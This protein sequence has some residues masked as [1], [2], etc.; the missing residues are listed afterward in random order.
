MLIL[1]ISSFTFRKRVDKIKDSCHTNTYTH[2]ICLI[3]NSDCRATC[4][5]TVTHSLSSKRFGNRTS[6]CCCYA[7]YCRYRF[8]TQY[9]IQ[10]ERKLPHSYITTCSFGSNSLYRAYWSYCVEVARSVYVLA[11]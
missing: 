6:C 8:E 5:H 2:H 3:G 10:T 11:I 7:V 1:L 9:Y 4:S